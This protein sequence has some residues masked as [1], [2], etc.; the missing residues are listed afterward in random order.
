MPALWRSLRPHQWIKNL[1]LFAAVVFAG[2]LREPRS[3]ALA[4][5]GFLLFCAIS[6]AIYIVNDIVD[7][8]QDRLHPHKRYRPIASGRVPVRMA[9]GVAVALMVGGLGGSFALGYGF[10]VAALAYAALSVAY[11]FGLKRVVI[12]DVMIVASGYSLRAVAGA[13][14]IQVVFSDWLLL[15]TS[16][17]ALFLG[18][19]KRRQELTSLQD[20]A[21]AHRAVLAR[22]S[23]QFLDQMIAVVTASTL[24]SYIFYT[25]SDEVAAKLGTPYL[26]A[27][28]PF[29]VYGVFRYFYLV[30]MRGEGGRPAREVIGDR[31][32]L[33]NLVL[34]GVT[35][36]LLLYT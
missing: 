5:A 2:Q 12:L 29:V 25:L 36:V 21:V 28:I 26:G 30:H 23:E 32:L 24:I 8:P 7:R 14:A 17:L 19:C 16:M 9:A 20:D 18:F 27:T 1:F 15:C 35:V 6:S 11:S 10:L 3:V 4:G 22:Y 31:P 34:Y 33:L 13:E